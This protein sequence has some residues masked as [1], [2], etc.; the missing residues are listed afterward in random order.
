V[1]GPDL[2]GKTLPLSNVTRRAYISTLQRQGTTPKH[3][4]KGEPQYTSLTN[5]GYEPGEI[6]TVKGGKQKQG[7]NPWSRLGMI[8]SMALSP[9]Y[10]GISGRSL[11]VYYCYRKSHEPDPVPLE[12]TQYLLRN[13]GPLRC[14]QALQVLSPYQ[15]REHPY[16]TGL[17]FSTGS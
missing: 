4:P 1:S 13:R 7:T 15:T 10:E 16:K 9:D 11:R 3:G 8:P 17:W 12:K 14:L 5:T 6:F 2:R